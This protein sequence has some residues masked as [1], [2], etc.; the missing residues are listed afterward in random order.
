MQH[1]QNQFLNKRRPRAELGEV[2]ELQS[3]DKHET[4]R[5][6][7]EEMRRDGEEKSNKLNCCGWI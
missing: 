5:R 4:P 7:R 6:D 1:G 3:E 2:P